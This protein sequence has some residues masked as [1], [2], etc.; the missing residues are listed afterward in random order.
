MTEP[1]K[2]K[3]IA[4]HKRHTWD[5]HPT[6]PPYYEAIK[7]WLLDPKRVLQGKKK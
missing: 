5:K 1:V 3:Y 4:L 7:T 6:L 2:E